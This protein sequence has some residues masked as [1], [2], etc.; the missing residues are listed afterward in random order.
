MFV[1]HVSALW[2]IYDVLAW[3]ICSEGLTHP[4]SSPRASF[5]LEA[6][7]TQLPEPE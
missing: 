5:V 3:S 6:W 4:F 1:E 7:K 2:F